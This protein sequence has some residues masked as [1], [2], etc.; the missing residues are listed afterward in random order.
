MNGP[1]RFAGQPYAS[2][3]MSIM[4]D[5]RLNATAKLTYTALAFY[6]RNNATSYPSTAQIAR[7]VG[8]SPRAVD[9][10]LADLRAAGYL[11]SR[12]RFSRAFDRRPGRDAALQDLAQG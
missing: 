6:Q 5:P 7:V 10:G 12:R 3:A 2:V 8:L 9:R 1:T 4:S 11:D